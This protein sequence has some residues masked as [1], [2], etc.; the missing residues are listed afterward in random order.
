MIADLYRKCLEMYRK[1]KEVILYIFF[2][3]LCTVVSIGS[4]A[5]CDVV[6]RMDPLIANVISW[7]LAVTFAY[8]TNRTWVFESETHGLKN[9]LR[10]AVGFYGGRVLTLIMEEV[11]LLIFINELGLPSIGV[12][13][14]AQVLVM[15]ANYVISKLIVFRK[16]R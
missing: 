7:I 11:V 1:Y 8:F 13:V 5:W 6:M 9:M 2:G 14:F 4:F 15:V 16:T 12:K 3:G 10:E